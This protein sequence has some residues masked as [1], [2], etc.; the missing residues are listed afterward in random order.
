V[1]AAID[2][3]DRKAIEEQKGTLLRE[4]N[5]RVKNNLAVVSGLLFLQAH[6]SGDV[7]VSAAIKNSRGRLDA[8]ALIHEHLYEH[9]DLSRV[10]IG[11]YLTR[12][13]EHI[14]EAELRPGIVLEL[15]SNSPA[16]ELSMDEAVACG[17]I[18]NELISNALEH[19]FTDHGSGTI[20][21]TVNADGESGITRLEVEDSG[22]GFHRG[23]D[24]GPGESGSLGFKL[25]RHLAAQIGLGV[26]IEANGG[27]GT[28]VVM[29]E[30]TDVA[31]V[32][33]AG[34]GAAGSDPAHSIAGTDGAPT[35][36]VFVVEDEHILVLSLE[37][38]A[39]RHGIAIVGHA[40]TGVEAI[41]LVE[42]LQEPPDIIVTDIR[43]RGGMDGIETARELQGRVDSLFLFQTGFSAEDAE[44]RIREAGIRRYR[45]VSKQRLEDALLDLTGNS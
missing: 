21:V 13:F 8:M 22:R 18:V 1:G 28:R 40:D 6:D 30:G 5:H 37:R 34:M 12:L 26:R 39:A 15:R 29:Q 23:L 17:L 25:V 4:V 19:A 24:S 43:I 10:E 9:D 44:R 45:L 41:A 42:N 31:T 38:W 7:R 27:G 20:V 3:T 36:R 35:P 11:P 32:E 33:E 16:L 2:I 14:R